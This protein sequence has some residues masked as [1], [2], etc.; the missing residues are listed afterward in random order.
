MHTN[1]VPMMQSPL[2]HRD[3]MARRPC[4][5]VAHHPHLGHP[6]TP[7]PIHHPIIPII[8]I[9]LTIL[10]ISFGT[11]DIIIITT[12]MVMVMRRNLNLCTELHRRRLALPAMRARNRVIICERFAKR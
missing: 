11:I 9:I 3:C 7:P 1:D 5:K 12:I 4:K 2:M 8:L 10:I 6:S